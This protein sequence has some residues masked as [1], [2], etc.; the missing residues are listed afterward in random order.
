MTSTADDAYKRKIVD[1][2]PANPANVKSFHHAELEVSGIISHSKR[3]LS[4][5]EKDVASMN[6]GKVSKNDID[7]ILYVSTY[8]EAFNPR[9]A[10]NLFFVSESKETKNAKSKSLYQDSFGND[11]SCQNLKVNKILN[12]DPHSFG[13]KNILYHQY[14]PG[15]N[16]IIHYKGVKVEEVLV[17]DQS[18]TIYKTSYEK[19]FS[20][21]KFIKDIPPEQIPIP[22]SLGSKNKRNMKFRKWG[23]YLGA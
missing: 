16:I 17:L 18:K 4:T 13:K 10:S 5:I 1:H 12:V 8:Q 22:S 7:S 20:E 19:D 6:I 11:N 3:K 23:G 14:T 21:R 15:N 9:I 2:I